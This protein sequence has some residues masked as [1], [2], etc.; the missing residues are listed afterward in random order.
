MNFC[1][2]FILKDLA[3]PRRTSKN[4]EL[5]PSCREISLELGSKPV[6]NR[7]LNHLFA[8][9]GQF[10]ANDMS[11][12]TPAIETAASKGSPCTCNSKENWEKCNVIEVQADDPYLSGQ[13][14]MVFPATAQAFKDQVCTFGVKEQMNGNT[15]FLDLS[16]VYGSSLPTALALRADKGQL[17]SATRYWLK[18]ELPPNQRQP[19]SC[20]DATSKRPC[21]A[22][23][24]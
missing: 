12:A 5:L 1:F 24:K 2:F 11:I 19:K 8:M 10:I 3:A 13:N 17:K 20:S 15:H 9:F 14:C 21:F 23:G 7:N 6:Y 4:G 18:H 22:S 16:T